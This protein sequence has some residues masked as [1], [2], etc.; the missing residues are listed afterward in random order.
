MSRPSCCQVPLRPSIPRSDCCH[1]R[2][3]ACAT[4]TALPA[5]GNQKGCEAMSLIQSIFLGFCNKTILRMPRSLTLQIPPALA[6]W[7]LGIHEPGS[8]TIHCQPSDGYQ[9]A[10][11]TRCLLP[12]GFTCLSVS[13]RLSFL[14]LLLEGH[15]PPGWLSNLSVFCQAVLPSRLIPPPGPGACC[16]HTWHWYKRGMSTG[17]AI[18]L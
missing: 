8:T 13:H 5:T 6:C 4:Q 16:F 10:S 18:Y 11:C 1:L 3:N 15:P 17:N 9:C 14:N 12:F 2:K 7:Q